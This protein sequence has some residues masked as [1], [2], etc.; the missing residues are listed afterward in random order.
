VGTGS[1]QWVKRPGRGVDHPFPSSS[2]VKERVELYLFS[3]CGPSWPVIGRTLP[4]PL[5]TLYK[6]KL[7]EYSDRNLKEEL[8]YEVCESAVT[9]W[10]E[11]SAEQKPI[12]GVL[13]LLLILLGMMLMI[14]KVAES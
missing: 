5:P 3:N 10:K 13:I 7:K 8:W 2:E 14:V 6:N 11:L 4:L 12:K 9:N 1:F